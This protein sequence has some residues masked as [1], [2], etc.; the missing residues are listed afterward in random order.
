[1]GKT[2]KKLIAKRR[3]LSK[4]K[5]KEYIEKRKSKKKLT[6]KQNKQLDDSLFT[7]YCECIKKI[8][9]DPKIKEGLEYP[10]CTSS[11][12]T[13]RGFKPPKDIKLRCKKYR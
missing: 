13:K 9:Y 6:K 2:K 10:F 3:T 7:K 12:Y 8:K 4:K 11:V 5:Y 1:M